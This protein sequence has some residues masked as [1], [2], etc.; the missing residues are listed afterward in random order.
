LVADFRAADFVPTAETGV[1]DFCLAFAWVDF[2]D[3]DFADA[4]FVDAD[5]VATV[6]ADE[7][8][9]AFVELVFVEP[10]FVDAVFA[11]AVFADGADGADT[12]AVAE[13]FLG[14][15]F[16]SVA[17]SAVI[18]AIGKAAET[19][20]TVRTLLSRTLLG[21]QKTRKESV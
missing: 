8:D 20:A 2:A 13:P 14:A 19:N 21:A 6:F 5:L 1:F 11:E 15:A 17:D 4:D 18:K 16:L 12:A 3:A 9:A 10:V 7:V